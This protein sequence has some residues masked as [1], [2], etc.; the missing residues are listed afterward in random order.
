MQQP[1]VFRRQVAFQDDL[2]A[3]LRSGFLDGGGQGE[4]VL[5]GENR[6]EEDMQ[7]AVARLDREGGADDAGITLAD[8]GQFLRDGTEIL[9][10][11][12]IRCY[13]RPMSLCRYLAGSG[14]FSLWRERVEFEVVFG[15]LPDRPRV[16]TSSGRR[17]PTGLSPGTRNISPDL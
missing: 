1:F 16:G 12:A 7:Q 15:L 8:D 13:G 4:P 11:A 9:D 2:A 14:N 3:D 6:R 5:N 17:R 10:T